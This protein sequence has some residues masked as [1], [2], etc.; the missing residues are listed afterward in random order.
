MRDDLLSNKFDIVAGKLRPE[1][2]DPDLD[3]TINNF[4]N[5]GKDQLSSL[6]VSQ[7]NLFQV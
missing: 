4:N 1:G 3:E 7:S 6:N 2:W 5:V